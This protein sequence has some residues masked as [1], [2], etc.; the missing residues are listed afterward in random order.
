MLRLTLFLLGGM[1][2]VLFTLGE[3]KG[4]LRPGLALAASEGRLDEVWAEARAAEAG[5][6]ALPVS[7]P[8]A[9][10]NPDPAP[11]PV[12]AETAPLPEAEAEPMAEAV[13]ETAAVDP[14]ADPAPLRDVVQVV[15][16]PVFSLSSFGNELVPGEDAARTDTL[17]PDA[18]SAALP[19]PQP[20]ALAGDGTI[21]YVNASSVNVRAEPST[22]AEVLGKLGNGE[23][24][25]MVSAV[26]DEWARIVIEGDGMEGYVALR[27]L[28]PEAP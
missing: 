17:A 1:F 24:T 26:D 20:E 4:Q 2:A 14:A 21:W 11:P 6:K 27:F 18:E 10:A 13:T 3:D 12:L 25:L 5:A 9:E 19:E 16:E 28:S 7:A 22:E 15:Q 8:V 23:A